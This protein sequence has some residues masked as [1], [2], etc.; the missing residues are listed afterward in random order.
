MPEETITVCGVH[1][2]TVELLDKIRE[3]MARNTA[4]VAKLNTS[5]GWIKW[6]VGGVLGV[7]VTILLAAVPFVANMNT[8]ISMLEKWEKAKYETTERRNIQSVTND[9]KSGTISDDK[10]VDIGIPLGIR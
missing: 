6:V 5:L 3:E 10:T 9:A 4:E 1:R 8:R 7:T 2:D